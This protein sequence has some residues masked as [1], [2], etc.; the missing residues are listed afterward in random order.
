MDIEMEQKDNKLSI[1]ENKIGVTDDKGV[2]ETT[3]LD[4]NK[5]SD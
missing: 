2:E 1:L 4:F 3:K 5:I